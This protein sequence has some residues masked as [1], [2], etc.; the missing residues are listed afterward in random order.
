[1]AKFER[2]ICRDKILDLQSQ[3][4]DILERDYNRAELIDWLVDIL[5]ITA[6]DEVVANAKEEIT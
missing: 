2:S 6:L 3:V 1:M 4:K 5:P